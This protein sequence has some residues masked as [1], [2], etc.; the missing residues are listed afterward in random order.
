MKDVNLLV[1]L[2]QLGLGTAL[3][4]AGC[5]YLGVWLHRSC[6]WG[7]WCVPAGA[8]LGFVMAV[9]GLRSSLQMMERMAGGADKKDEPPPVSFNEHK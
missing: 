1:W 6:G 5:V 3:P 2:T 8:A 7:A 9:G 4:L